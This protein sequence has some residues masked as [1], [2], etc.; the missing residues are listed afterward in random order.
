MTPDEADEVWPT[1]AEQAKA[2]EHHSSSQGH[3]GSSDANSGLGTPLLEGIPIEEAEN[4]EQEEQLEAPEDVT[5][6][7]LV[8]ES[9]LLGKLMLV[10]IEGGPAGVT[11]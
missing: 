11:I 1:P 5:I 9:G 7:R 6:Q 4:Q 10:E 8:R 2:Q 3:E